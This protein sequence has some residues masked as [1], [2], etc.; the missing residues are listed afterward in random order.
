MHQLTCVAM[1]NWNF[2][3]QNCDLREDFVWTVIYPSDSTVQRKETQ[4]HDVL[5]YKMYLKHNNYEVFKIKDI[6]P[7]YIFSN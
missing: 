1:D 2:H 7:L 5:R 3:F 4:F 6:F